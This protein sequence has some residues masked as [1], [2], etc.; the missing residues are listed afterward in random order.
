MND[1]VTF[2]E[3]GRE[4]HPRIIDTNLITRYGLLEGSCVIPNN[5]IYTNDDTWEKVVKMVSPGIRKM[6][7]IT[8]AFVLPVLLSIYLT[9]HLYS[10]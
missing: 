2:M 3:K 8:V 9:H 1:P 7:V 5:E 4:V 10:S 6:K